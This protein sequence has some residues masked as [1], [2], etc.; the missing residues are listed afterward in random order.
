M[1]KPETLYK[2]IADFYA[3]L[4]CPQCGRVLR[5][6]EDYEEV[7]CD[8]CHESFRDPNLVFT[9]LENKVNELEKKFATHVHT[10]ETIRAGEFI[11]VDDIE[12]VKPPEP[13]PC[14]NCPYQKTSHNE[15]SHTLG[16]D[17]SRRAMCFAW[18]L[19]EQGYPIFGTN[20][21]GIFYCPVCGQR[22]HYPN[23]E[24][25]PNILCCPHCQ[26]SEK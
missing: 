25:Q 3:P 23:V 11:A 26:W 5:D 18:K 4:K 14:N 19:W 8:K 17:C 10:K 6:Q 7:Y 16:T 24:P 21:R 1:S 12:K 9:Q 22:A 13:H 20:K 2:Q 15:P